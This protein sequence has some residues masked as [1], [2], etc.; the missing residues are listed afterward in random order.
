VDPMAEMDRKTNPYAYTFNNP[1]RFVD[2]DGMFGMETVSGMDKMMEF[3]EEDITSK[4]KSLRMKK[5][6]CK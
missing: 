4:R 1:I 6:H 2:P 3:R 5:R